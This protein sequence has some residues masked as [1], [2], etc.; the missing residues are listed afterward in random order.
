[1]GKATN[2][3]QQIKHLFASRPW[4]TQPT[5]AP[6]ILPNNTATSAPRR[7]AHE[8]QWPRRTFL[9]TYQYKVTF[10]TGACSCPWA[11]AIVMPYSDPMCFHSYALKTPP[12]KNTLE[13]YS[14]P[15]NEWQ[16]QYCNDKEI[17]RWV[18]SRAEVSEVTD[19]RGLTTEILGMGVF[20]GP[21]FT[22]SGDGVTSPMRYLNVVFFIHEWMDGIYI[23]RD[24]EDGTD[25]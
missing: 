2:D 21:E 16:R 17:Y 8:M 22:S 18:S 13:E 1:M 4:Q 6:S 5:P 3:S 20:G 19:R 24:F 23:H 15:S 10:P 14:I 9:H 12:K 25:R 7:C 11:A